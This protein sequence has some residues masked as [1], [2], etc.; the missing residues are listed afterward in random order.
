MARNVS[1]V[2][3][4]RAASAVKVPYVP[5]LENETNAGHKCRSDV[6]CVVRCVPVLSIVASC[7]NLALIMHPVPQ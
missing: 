4:A 6:K 7:V 2:Q 1:S 5:E 3:Q